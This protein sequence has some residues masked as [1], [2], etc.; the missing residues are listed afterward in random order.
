MLRTASCGRAPHSVQIDIVSVTQELMEFLT[1][2]LMRPL[3]LT[4]QLMRTWLDV[5]M[6]NPFVLHMPMKQR[7][8]LVVAVCPDGVD[9][10]REPFEH[11]VDEADRV[12][13]T[14]AR[15][16]SECPYSRGIVYGRLLE[17]TNGLARRPLEGE[18]LHVHL[19]MMAGYLLRITSGVQGAADSST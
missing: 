13:L 19:N 5:H 3:D 10:E 17:A 9:P 7:L 18:D 1:I 14:V 4:G 2:G 15:V 8:E 16:D 6:S 11:T 12:G